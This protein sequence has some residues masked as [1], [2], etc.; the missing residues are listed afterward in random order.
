V[1]SGGGPRQ[2]AGQGVQLTLRGRRER[3]IEALVELLK[4]QPALR[5]VLAQSGGRRLTVGVSDT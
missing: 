4:G 2:V 5:V 3:G 1:R